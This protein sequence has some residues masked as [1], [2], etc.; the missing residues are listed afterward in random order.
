MK[1]L[2][3]I[4]IA[5]IINF[6]SCKNNN[7]ATTQ[8]DD[9]SATTDFT[10]FKIK[11]GTNIAHWLSQSE[12]R[13]DKREEFFTKKDVQFIAEL[14]F[15]H[16]RIPIDEEQMWDEA[17]NQHPEAFQLL[18]DA[19][20]WC[21]KF[22]LRVVVDLH[23]LRS[24]HFNA[25]EKPLWTDPNEQNEFIDLWRDL[26]AALNKWPVGMVAYELMNEPVA[27]DPENWN[28]LVARAVSALRSLEPNRILVVGSNRFQS[29]HTFDQLKVPDD[30]NI[31]LSFHFYEP[32]LLTHY[33]ASWTFLKDYQG[34][35]NYPGQ[36]IP[37]EKMEE[38]STE[39]KDRAASMNKVYHLDTLEKMM[40]K[41]FNKAKETNLNLFCGEFGV[42][43]KAPREDMLAWYKDMIAIFEK[44]DVAYANWNYKSDSF[45]LVDGE[46]NPDQE[47]I[48]IVLSKSEI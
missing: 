28:Q 6:W 20:S 10:E 33:Q 16:I 13:G 3:L 24:H 36:L 27:D 29:A 25:Q 39:W 19:I 5:I 14:G 11:R 31:L 45:G 18:D 17:G 40:E 47:L 2:P 41:P 26:S 21:D 32:F 1:N 9:T 22:G 15:D 34:P 42:L 35:V 44:N 4:F 43:Q 8:R 46:G 37:L 23:I 30:Q 12:R 48:D 7:Q 38:V